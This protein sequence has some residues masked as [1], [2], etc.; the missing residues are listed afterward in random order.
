MHLFTSQ[1]TIGKSIKEFICNNGYTITSFSRLVNLSKFSLNQIIEG[2]I[3]NPDIYHEYIKKITEALSLPYDYFLKCRPEK[4][5]KWQVTSL[6]GINQ[7]PER[8]KIAQELLDDLDEL[9]IVAVFYI[10]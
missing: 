10:K 7:Y 6:N 4:L 2:I 3:T 9:L 8:S 1:E 5:E